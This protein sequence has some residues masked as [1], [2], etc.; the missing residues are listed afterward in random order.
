[1]EQ[2]TASWSNF[3]TRAEAVAALASWGDDVMLKK[4]PFAQV[5]KAHSQEFAADEGG[6]HDWSTQGS[7]RSTKL[8]AALYSI[9]IGAMSRI[10][11]D[12]EGCHIVRVL[13][14]E[15]AV[16]TP[17]IDVQPEIKKALHD[18]G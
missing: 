10:V 9:P 11:E 14:R 16:T 7:L 17:F 4:I 5:A 13:E 3:G 6:Q 2:I 15:E 1:W 12:E 8:E 18:G